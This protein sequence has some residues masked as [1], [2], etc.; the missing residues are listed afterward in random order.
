MIVTRTCPSCG[1]RHSYASAA[2]ADAHHGR[3]SCERQRRLAETARRR[4]T[5]AVRRDCTHPGLPHRHGTRVA[6]VKD[7]CRCAECT[8]ANTAAQRAAERARALGQPSRYV[9]AA[10][11]RAHIQRLRAAGLGYDQIAKIAHTSSSHVREIAQT[12]A[13]SGGRGPLQRVSRA[14]AR[15]IL[16][17]AATPANRASH[18]KIEATGTRRRLQAL[19]AIGHPPAELAHRLN[20]SLTNL[21]RS[22]DSATVTA[23]TAQLVD[24]LYEQLWNAPP[25]ADTEQ[26]R[27]ASAA[28]RNL[29]TRHGWRPPLAWDD[30]EADPDPDPH[31]PSPPRDPQDIDQIAVERAVAGDGVR[32]ADL[33]PAEQAEAVR[34]LTERGKSIRDIADQL[35]TTKRT[36]SRRRRATRAA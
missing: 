33:T 5:R 14:L 26:Q 4:A 31:R 30:I 17:I 34:R 22:M 23:R 21:R 3:H 29:A 32:L 1:Y 12:S 2:R 6:Y 35:A 24:E 8:A 16:A 19:V 18:S 15:R 27:Q 25:A 10:P 13:R 11:V 36:V 9:D 7:R 28:A 20:R